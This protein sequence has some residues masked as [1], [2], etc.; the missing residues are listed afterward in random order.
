MSLATYL[1]AMVSIA[2]PPPAELA[3]IGCA[4]AEV[5]REDG[6]ARNLRVRCRFELKIERLDEAARRPLLPECADSGGERPAAA[7]STGTTDDMD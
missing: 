4:I 3:S 7:V 6:T 1:V 2:E 5:W